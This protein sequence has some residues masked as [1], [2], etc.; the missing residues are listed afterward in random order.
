MK[1]PFIKTRNLDFCLGQ[2]KSVLDGKKAAIVGC[3]KAGIDYH[4]KPYKTAG[5][6]VV[7]LCDLNVDLA[8]REAREHNIRHWYA[9]LDEALNRHD[10]DIVSICTQPK[11]HL[12]L[13]KK[14]LDARVHVLVEKP[15]T[16]FRRE[17]DDLDSLMKNAKS[18]LTVVHNKKF[19]PGIM[20]AKE[21]FDSG[22]LGEVLQIDISWITN[23]ERD[24]FIPHENHWSH[25]CIGGRWAEVAPHL[26]YL[27]YQFCG[28]M[29]LLDVHVMNYN[30]HR[31]WL[32]GDDASVQLGFKNG[33]VNL[34]FGHSHR[35]FLRD[36]Y[37]DN[38]NI[39]GSDGM[40]V[41]YPRS[42]F[43]LQTDKK[44][45]LGGWPRKR[46]RD[47]TQ[48]AFVREVSIAKNG[49]DL[50]VKNFLE[51]VFLDAPSATPW[52]EA[53]HVMELT[54]EVGEALDRKSGRKLLHH[55]I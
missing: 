2:L 37:T 35:G 31:P 43:M 40:L 20:S 27:A 6:E 47:I 38:L 42:C 29:R 15:V 21:F 18:K 9:S 26:L 8:Q 33:F 10:V 17:L 55:G 23:V 30:N 51:Y 41:V 46:L 7:A 28:E 45:G 34:R 24:P 52:S 11:T 5:I 19:Y 1:I 13:C 49:H 16:M 48:K 12:E 32:P 3:G 44:F 53:K 36:N 14:A 22:K 50:V 4:M 25:Q 54:L 39:Y